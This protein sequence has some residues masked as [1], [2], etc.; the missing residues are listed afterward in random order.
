MFSNPFSLLIF[1]DFLTSK[2]FFEQS[3][4]M[5][6]PFLC[7]IISN[8][9]LPFTNKISVS[10]GF[11]LFCSTIIIILLL[12]SISNSFTLFSSFTFLSFNILFSPRTGF[13]FYFIFQELYQLQNYLLLLAIF[14]WFYLTWQST[15]KILSQTLHSLTRNTNTSIN[16]ISL[17][18]KITL[19]VLFN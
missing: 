13:Y 15:E 12:L 2:V 8:V 9:V 4:V 1:H 10:L 19:Y 3:F 18:L 14:R 6:N 11:L 16:D 17:W 5:Y 7:F